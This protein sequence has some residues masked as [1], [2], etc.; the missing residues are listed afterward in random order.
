VAS[1]PL[2]SHVLVVPPTSAPTS[3]LE[4]VRLVDDPGA[5]AVARADYD[6]T[7]PHRQ[8]DVIALVNERLGRE[9]VNA[10]AILS[11]R[12][13]HDVD[14]REE[15]YHHPRFGTPQYTDAFVDWLVASY[16]QDH[17]FFDAAKAEYHRRQLARRAG[18]KRPALTPA[19]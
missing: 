1:A 10:H 5:P 7:H 6:V 12:R 19:S 2:G 3:A 9:L 15:W 8:K 14:A 11:V 16:E 17:A 4:R 18:Q 13:V